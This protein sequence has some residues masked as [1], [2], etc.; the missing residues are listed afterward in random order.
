MEKSIGMPPAIHSFCLGRN[1]SI[2]PLFLCAAK[3]K[4]LAVKRKRQRGISIS[5]FAIPL[6]RPRRGLRPPSLD[7]PRGLVCTGVIS[8]Q[9]NAM[10][11]RIEQTG[12]VIE[13]LCAKI[14]RKGMS[15]PTNRLILDTSRI[16]YVKY[17]TGAN[18]TTCT[19]YRALEKP[20]STAARRAFLAGRIIVEWHA[21]AK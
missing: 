15:A 21:E 16:P 17:S 1:G 7:F 3:K 12:E 6:K 10:Q 2:Q 20:D 19:A 13:I 8:D 9:Q 14:G 4:P 18:E 5:P 11:M